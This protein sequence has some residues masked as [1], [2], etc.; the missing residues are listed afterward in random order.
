MKRQVMLGALLLAALVSSLACSKREDPILRLSADEALE[1]GKQ[2]MA[3]EK[4]FKA[5]QHLTHAF[6]VEP[7]SRKGR[8]A[9]LMAADALYQDGGLDNYIRCE[10]K[11]R[12]FLNRF[13]TSGQA[14]YAQFQIASCLAKRVEKPDRDQKV[15]RKALEAYEELLRIYPTSAYAAEARQQ[16]LEVTDLL[17]EHELVIAVFYMRYGTR[18][19]CQ[20]SLNRLEHLRDN[21]PTF[22]KKDAMLFHLGMAYE[23]CRRPD[24]AEAAFLELRQDHPDSEYLDG[25]ERARKKNMKKFS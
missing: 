24:D 9:L 17:A 12:D 6:E 22:S 23:R 20:A 16:I 7:N 8:E 11:Y 13:P 3:D 19:F 15:T 14:D 4:F 1:I 2:L 25:L 21:Y 5:S 18:G 10:A